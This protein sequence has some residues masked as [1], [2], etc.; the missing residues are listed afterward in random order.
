MNEV[1][2]GYT[3]HCCQSSETDRL[4]GSGM[5]EWLLKLALPR[6][7]AGAFLRL[8]LALPFSKSS[9]L[10]LRQLSQRDF[11]Q[12]YLVL[13]IGKSK[14][15]C[16]VYNLWND[17][18][19]AVAAFLK[20]P[21]TLKCTA[22]VV[23]PG[24]SHRLTLLELLARIEAGH[25][26]HFSP[27]LISVMGGRFDAAQPSRI[28]LD[29][30]AVLPAPPE[31]KKS[32]TYSK[33]LTSQFVRRLRQARRVQEASEQE[34]IAKL[35][36]LRGELRRAQVATQSEA[37]AIQA[38][39]SRLEKNLSLQTEERECRA[40]VAALSILDRQPAAI[41][42]GSPEKLA[43]SLISKALQD[44]KQKPIEVKAGSPEDLA[45]SVVEDSIAL[46]AKVEEVEEDKRLPTRRRRRKTELSHPLYHP[47]TVLRHYGIGDMPPLEIKHIRESICR[48]AWCIL[49]HC[50]RRAHCLS[51]IVLGD[52]VYVMDPLTREW[53][54]DLIIRGTKSRK[55][56]LMRIPLS[57][58]W[59]ESEL[60][61]LRLLL[62]RM[63]SEHPN[64]WAGFGL[65]E[66]I[67]G[68]RVKKGDVD[69]RSSHL[70]R[71]LPRNRSWLH[72]PRG[73]FASWLVI[74]ILCARDRRLLERSWFREL[75]R[76]PWFSDEMLDK[77]LRLI[78][79]DATDALEVARRLMGHASTFELI[80]SYCTSWAIQG[81]M[82]R[83]V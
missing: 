21:V 15:V 23:L 6:R 49:V 74:R 18:P 57:L 45:L 2:L 9:Y 5:R 73:N 66:L 77:L 31:A 58:L 47:Q 37:A 42:V 17:D 19:E 30:P 14:R 16:W 62:D 82:L 76:C 65:M 11:E 27:I 71:M 8:S 81:E 53:V 56:S 41:T 52:F 54:V 24:I 80:A 59:P 10:A 44:L 72:L 75:R 4:R 70:R 29:S 34:Q 32:R 12:P 83:S 3:S 55:E 35:D 68:E 46:E 26:G 69:E 40:I 61:H 48:I 51:K 60:V 64:E 7:S 63:G 78:G 20:L 22:D 13:K 33:N 28:L 43:F 50:G 79:N 36:T 67:S 38:I 25:V 39:N 1:N